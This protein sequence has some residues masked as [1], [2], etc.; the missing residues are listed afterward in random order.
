LDQYQRMMNMFFRIYTGQPTPRG[1]H[2]EGEKGSDV[3][4]EE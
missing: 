3:N 4:R 2:P 1:K